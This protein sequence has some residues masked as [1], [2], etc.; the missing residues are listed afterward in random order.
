MSHD[1]IDHIPAIVPGREGGPPR[2]PRQGA[3][4]R[5]R[6][7]G[8]RPQ[9]PP[10]GGAGTLSRLLAGL[11]LIAGG[12]A[13]AWAWQLQNQLEQARGEMQGYEQRIGDLEARL[14]DT[15]EGMTQ[16]A[17]VQA[18]KIAELDTEVRKLWDNVW[19]QTRERLEKLE[20]ASD[21]QGK[22]IKGMDSSLAAVKTQLNQANTELGQLKSVGGDL[23]RLMASAKASQA[24]VERVAD[25]LNRIELSMTRLEKRVA[26]NEEWVDSVNAFRRQVN[27]SLAEL[28]DTVR[29]LQAVP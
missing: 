24:E 17:A 23:A 19:K 22:G 11:A 16:N 8:T 12:L 6:G 20:A 7:G 5:R 3:S 28:Q 18:V 2:G 13:F 26:G 1:D 21:S 9:A 29:T 10:S 27:A 4:E 15:D 25:S 14:S